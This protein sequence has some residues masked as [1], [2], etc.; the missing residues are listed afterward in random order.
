MAEEGGDEGTGGATAD[1]SDSCSTSIGVGT[2]GP[3]STPPPRRSAAPARLLHC[4]R[5]C[6][7]FAPPAPPT[8]TYDAVLCQHSSQRGLPRRA[9]CRCGRCWLLR[10]RLAL[11]G[12]AGFP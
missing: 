7:A 4:A 12:G 2:S 10:P 1:I 6:R 5:R 9:A 11:A 3:C 8:A